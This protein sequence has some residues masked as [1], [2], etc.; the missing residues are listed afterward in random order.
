V[1]IL[2]LRLAQLKKMHTLDAPFTDVTG[3]K[4]LRFV[5]EDILGGIF[6][7]SQNY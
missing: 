2:T 3:R 7:Y 5:K 1:Y 6:A 4:E